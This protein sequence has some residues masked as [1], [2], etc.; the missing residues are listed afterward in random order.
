MK[1]KKKRIIREVYK[2]LGTFSSIQIYKN[3]YCILQT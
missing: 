1:S 3:N 2:I